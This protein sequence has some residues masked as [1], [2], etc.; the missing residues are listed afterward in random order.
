MNSI[1]DKRFWRTIKP[2]F[3]DMVQTTPSITFIENEKLITDEIAITEIFNAF[4]ANIIDVI[5]TTTSEFIPST[6]GHLLNPIEIATG[7]KFRY[8]PSILKIK[9]K[10]DYTSSFEI[11]PV[12]VITV[13]E[14]L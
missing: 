7:K 9:G 13:N 1:T 3:T 14:E 10:V 4:F 11:G 5:D 2:Q 6:T 12:T 8:H